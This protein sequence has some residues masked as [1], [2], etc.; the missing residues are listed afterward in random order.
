[1]KKNKTFPCLV[2]VKQEMGD[3]VGEYGNQKQTEKKIDFLKKF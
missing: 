1:M 3:A 2:F